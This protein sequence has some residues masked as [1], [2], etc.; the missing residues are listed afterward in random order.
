MPT[1]QRQQ[2]GTRSDYERYLQ[3]MDAS[4]QQKVALTAA[5]LLGRGWLADMGM[6]SGTG[7]EALAAL[8]PELRVTG[9]DISSEMVTLARERYQR[10]NLDFQVG[11][12]SQVCFDPETLDVV[13]DSSV[14]HHVTTFNGYDHSKASEAIENQVKLLKLDGN[15]IIRD[16]VRPE[17][18][19]V[20]MELPESTVALFQRFAR[21]FRYLKPED[22]RGFRY[23]ELP[24]DTPGWKRF[25]LDRVHAVEF[26]LRKDYTTD[27][28]SEVLEEYTYFTQAEFESTFRAQKLR[29]LASTPIRNPWIIANR[30]EGQLRMLTTTGEP[31]EFPPTNYLIVGEKVKPTE[32]VE[33]SHGAEVEAGGYLEMCHYQHSNGVARRDLIRRPNSTLDVVPYFQQGDEIYVLARKSYPRPLLGLC[34]DRLDGALSPTYV[35]EPIVVIQSDKPIAQTVEEALESRAGIEPSS[36]YRFDFGSP[37]YPSPGGL[38]EEVRPVFV[39][40]EPCLSS[41]RTER[42]RAVAARQ[43]LRAAQV[44]GLPDARL[45]LHICE[46]L[47]R[48]GQPTGSWIGEQLSLEAAPPPPVT[49]QTLPQ[50]PPRRAYRKT[51]KSADFL[52]LGCRSFQALTH[53][54]ETVSEATL[55]YCLPSKFSLHTAAVILLWKCPD[56]TYAGLVDDD[57]PAAQCFRGHSNLWVTPAWRLP[58]TIDNL[59]KMET[60]VEQKLAQEH[61][62]T[63]RKFF[64]LGGP[65]YPSPGATPEIVY[66]LACETRGEAPQGLSWVRIDH[67]QEN[68]S[69]LRDG[70]LKVLLS[71]ASRALEDHQPQARA[72]TP[73]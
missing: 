22:E 24:C 35:T 60:F 62:L 57:F 49:Q 48:L 7:S 29:I 13:F 68:F 54:G 55:E 70:H 39:Q 15:L 33:F 47:A 73:L 36:L 66:P 50:P 38:Q 18:G 37:T 6:G 27:W 25:E 30:F 53:S 59:D 20:W 21:E 4:M 9:V 63:A 12:I 28:E 64:T 41:E 69:A 56:G 14:L 1:Y 5:Y 26:I 40:V 23:R 17:P 58:K 11:D 2:R 61:A 32:D 46:L 45:E 65:Y 72:E 42:V 3:G 34:D 52:H 43:L 51:E 19:A 8:Y 67:L 44:G 71:R 16:F 10:P 31:M